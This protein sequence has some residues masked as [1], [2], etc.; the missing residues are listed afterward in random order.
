MRHALTLCYDFEWVNRVLLGGRHGRLTSTFPNSEFEAKG[1]P[2]AGELKLLAPFRAD[3]PQELF[4]KPLALP[5]GGDWS[6]RRA[7]LLA[8]AKLLR[9]AGFRT[10]NGRLIDPRTGKPVRLQL[11]A[12]SAL[13]D[14][15]VSLFTD[16]A[17]RLGIEIVFRN[18]DSAQ[19]RV[20]MRDY[21]YDILAAQQ[22]LAT[23]MTPGVG[24][25]QMWSAKAADTPQ[26]L[27]YP[28]AKNPALDAMINVV[29]RATD[30]TDVVN[31]MRALDR[32]A[33][34]NYY[35]IPMQHGYPAPLGYLPVTYWDRFGRPAVEQ[36]Y[37]FN[38]QT[39]DTWW[40]DKA[41]EAR[42]QHR[43]PVQ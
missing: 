13:I 2:G 11:L 10:V 43:R 7:N 29:V 23:S 12:F 24:L 37:N 9:E 41:R 39:L 28:G 16:N 36:T 31:A 1:L 18:V 30:R 20:M 33:Q 6:H 27:N 38:V 32:I 25:L 17:R 5:V 14:R 40:V 35:A 26:Q 4:T 8:A 21:D 19:L 22:L 34:W 42:L 15:Q 3:L